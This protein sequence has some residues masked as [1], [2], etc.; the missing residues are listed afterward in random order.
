VPHKQLVVTHQPIRVQDKTSNG[1]FD[2]CE[3]V[4]L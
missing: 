3:C 2:S 4:I 1:A